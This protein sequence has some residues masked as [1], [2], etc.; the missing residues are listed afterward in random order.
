MTLR[1][2]MVAGMPVAQNNGGAGKNEEYEN[3]LRRI[4][5]S[6]DLCTYE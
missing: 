4:Y 2:V 6:L 1:L 5:P 3:P